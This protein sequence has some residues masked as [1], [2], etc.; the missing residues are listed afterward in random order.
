MET[1]LA[2]VSPIA[3]WKPGFAPFLNVCL[4]PSRLNS[5]RKWLTGKP[6]VVQSSACSTEYDPFR[7]E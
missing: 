2:M 4:S 7:D 1:D 5:T 3:S 6:R